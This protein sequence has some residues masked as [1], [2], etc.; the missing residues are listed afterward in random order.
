MKKTSTS[1]LALFALLLAATGTLLLTACKE[2]EV[3]E[4]FDNWQERNEAFIDSI[5]RVCDANADGRWMKYLSFKLNQKDDKGNTTSWGKE[6]YVYCHSE[7][8]GA[9][10]VCPLFTDTVAC[11]YRGRLIPSA[12]YPEGYVFDQSY[13]GK[14]IDPEINV[15]TSFSVGSL[16]VGWCTFLHYMHTGDT[17][18]VYVPAE[19]GYGTQK[20]DK[21][22]AS[23]A[24]VFDV[25]LAGIRRPG[26][27]NL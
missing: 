23:S 21:I 19:L 13:K 27:G 24:L 6:Y 1:P 22:P 17:W 26:E 11:N 8:K 10:T 3:T 25:N 5:A 7:V 15:P 9:G 16:T 2:T 18:K 20:K 4:E 12:S 14:T